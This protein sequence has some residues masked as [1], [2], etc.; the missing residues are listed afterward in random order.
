MNLIDVI[1]K[2]SS[3]RGNIRIMKYVGNDPKRFS[4]LMNLITTHP[5]YSLFTGWA[6]SDLVAEHPDLI[7]PYLRNLL[8]LINPKAHISIKRNTMRL[9]QFIDIPKN[10]SGLILDKAFSLFTDRSESIAVRVFAM[11]VV[12]RIAKQEPDLKNEIILMI[13]EELPYGG[14]AFVSRGRKELKK[15][16]AEQKN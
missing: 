3:V 9:L 8:K 6:M 10:L 5:E 14:P 13:E 11:T 1:G 12:C 15:L 2:K 4:E 16:K 7:K